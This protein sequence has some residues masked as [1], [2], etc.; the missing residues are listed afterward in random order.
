MNPLHIAHV[1]EVCLLKKKWD[2]PVLL[3]PNQ[4]D[5]KC[6][7]DLDLQCALMLLEHRISRGDQSRL[8]ACVCG[9]EVVGALV[10]LFLLKRG[11][12]EVVV[13]S[14]SESVR[15]RVKSLAELNQLRSPK[16]GWWTDENIYGVFDMLFLPYS[17]YKQEPVKWLQKVDVSGIL[18]V[19]GHSDQSLGP[20]PGFQ[21]VLEVRC[22]SGKANGFF[23]TELNKTP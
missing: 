3:S 6:S 12:L 8:V 20:M 19:L 11:C 15:D 14:A 18:V 2:S 22:P 4:D 9:G 17:L 23:R 13:G 16:M 7:V 10:S 21:K 1:D 5:I